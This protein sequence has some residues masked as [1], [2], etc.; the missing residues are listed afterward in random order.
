MGEKEI[1]R[2]TKPMDQTVCDIGHY[3]EILLLYR[4]RLSRETAALEFVSEKHVI[5]HAANRLHRETHAIEIERLSNAANAFL[6]HVLEDMRF[7]DDFIISRVRDIPE[8]LR[9][10]FYAARDLFSVGFDEPALFALARAF[11]RVA[12]RILHERRIRIRFKGDIVDAC[13]VSLAEVIRALGL[14]RWKA[15]GERL[16]PASVQQMLHW[17]RAL[18]NESAHEA[19]PVGIDPYEFGPIIADAANALYRVHLVNRRRP[20]KTTVF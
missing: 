17:L 4:R 11:E 8:E 18:R 1:R 9:A 6:K 19:I 3:G 16:L 14:L 13:E 15:S 7:A 12:R 2:L 20:L 5:Q 10:D